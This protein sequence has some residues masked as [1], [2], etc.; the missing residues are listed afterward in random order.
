[1]TASVGTQVCKIT[2]RGPKA[3]IDVITEDHVTIRVDL[4]NAQPGEDMFV[5]QVYVD[6]AFPGV[7]ALGTYQISVRVSQP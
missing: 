7:G 1:M 3:Q 2:V 4:T 6:G 5:A